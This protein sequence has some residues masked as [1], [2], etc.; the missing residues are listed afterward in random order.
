MVC[1]LSALRWQRWLNL[2]IDLVQV[3]TQIGILDIRYL[4]GDGNAQGTWVSV[5]S[6]HNNTVRCRYSAV[7]F[8]KNIH[9]RHP[10][11]RYG[12]LLCIQH[13][14]DILTESLQS[15][16]QYLTKLDHVK[17]T[18]D[19]IIL[20]GFHQTMYIEWTKSDMGRLVYFC[21]LRLTCYWD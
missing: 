18:L 15:F 11:A 4:C 19:C 12:C 17:T 21:K 14:T 6:C 16:M 5:K 2:I 8:L 20:H 1:G 7:N 3:C 10:I 9:E 13:L